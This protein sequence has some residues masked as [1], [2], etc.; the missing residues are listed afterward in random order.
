[1]AHQRPSTTCAGCRWATSPGRWPVSKTI[2]SGALRC[3][4]NAAI[5]ASLST[6]SRLVVSFRSTPAHG[7]TAT[8]SC[9]AAQPKI[10][11]AAASTWFASTGAAIAATAALT[12]ERLMLPMSSLA[13][14]GFKY[15][16]TN[17][18]ACRQLLFRLRACSST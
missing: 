9:R 11:L 15:R 5:S 17:T 12:S 2:L 16:V 1:M 8:M 4:Q 13:Q 10:A 3:G 14:R 18:S 7:F 6:G